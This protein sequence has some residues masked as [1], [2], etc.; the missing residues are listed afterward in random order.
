M[1]FR[2]V[3]RPVTSLGLTGSEEAEIELLNYGTDTIFS[4]PVGFFLD[5][6]TVIENISDTLL[7]GEKYQ[8]IFNSLLDLSRPGDYTLTFFTAL[9]S[10]EVLVNDTLTLTV[11]HLI[12]DAGISRILS[13]VSDS[14]FSDSEIVKA[15]LYNFGTNTLSGIPVVYRVNEGI[16]ISEISDSLLPPGDSLIYVFNTT[17][18][19]SAYDTFLI[20]VYIDLLNDYNRENDTSRLQIERLGSN[21]IVPYKQIPGLS[22]YPN[23][24]YGQINLSFNKSATELQYRIQN[25]S[26]K[27]LLQRNL[28]VVN[29]GRNVT[30]DMVDLPAGMY[31]LIVE[32]GNQRSV[33]KIIKQ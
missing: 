28:P 20:T 24:T 4:L 14:V 17:T 23:P 27:I 21:G 5:G 22:I 7:P 30:I 3:I 32:S 12:Q 33:F 10:D 9:P 26:G 8:Y 19:L 29:E 15:V 18:D 11:R 2:S 1:L 25:L 16:E 6:D 13:P 31:L